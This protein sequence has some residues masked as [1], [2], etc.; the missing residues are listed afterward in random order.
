MNHYPELD[1][2][3]NRRSMV[4][5]LL[6]SSIR[7]IRRQKTLSVLKISGLAIGMATFLITALF[8]LHELKFDH[9][10]R[11]FQRIFRYVHR[12]NSDNNLQRFAFTSAT[13]GPA[14]IQRYQEVE[15]CTRIFKSVVS[16]K[17][18]DADV[19]FIEKNFAFAD[20]NFLETFS[21]PLRQ[22]YD[23]GI[24]KDPNAL[25]ITPG[26]AKKYFGDQDPIG[27][28]ILLNGQI[29]LTVKGVFR[30]NFT[31]SHFNFDFVCSFA[32]IE[33]IKNNPIVSKQIPASLNLENK[34]F[35]AFYTYLKLRSPGDANVLIGKFPAFIEDFRGKGR[36]ERLKPTL[37]SLESIH[38][39]SDMLYEIDKNGS[40]KIVFIYSIVGVLILITAII[41]YVNI[42]MAEFTLRAKG[43]GLKKIL[44]I[45][46]SSLWVSHFVETLVFCFGAMLS[47]CLLGL[48]LL[49]GFNTLMETRISFFS[50]E[51]LILAGLIFV[52]TAIL[53]GCL[54]AIQITRQN[55]LV[56]FKGSFQST[57]AALVLRHSLVFVQ[58]LVSFVLLTISM[59]I[60][61]QIDY[62]LQKDPGFDSDQIMVVNA[63][64]LSIDERRSIKTRLSTDLNVMGTSM[65][66]NPARRTLIYLRGNP[67]G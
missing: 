67:P 1:R 39:H 13:T 52:I 28:S 61:Q 44:G 66:S 36:S 25:L 59:L 16:L 62:L 3:K 41:N 15:S 24:F 64:S 6:K 14:L 21:F 47:G 65:C 35:A 4:T 56:A 46:R 9:Q 20:A 17:R 19:G 51:T 63:S 29:E 40:L 58:L 57:K 60:F 10:H 11:D 38:L 53:S 27:K 5:V 33:V 30:E 26:M 32:T 7:L 48:L 55:P 37:Q 54:P 2:Y 18:D 42:S 45:S 43:V 31:R 34:G 49:P 23:K 12:V 50:F 8:A 22:G